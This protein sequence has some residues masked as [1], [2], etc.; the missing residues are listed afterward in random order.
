[1]LFLYKEVLGRELEWLDNVER[2]KGPTRL[3]VVLTEAEVWAL[4][5]QMEGRQYGAGL[6]LMECMRLRVK[7]VDFGYAQ[8]T[9]R[10]GKGEKDRGTILLASLHANLLTH[11]ERVKGRI[12]RSLKTDSA[13]SI[14]RSR[15]PASIRGPAASGVDSAHPVLR[16]PGASAPFLS[17]RNDGSMS[18]RP[19]SVPS[20]HA[21]GQSGA[22]TSTSRPCSGRSRRPSGQPG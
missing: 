19:P 16:P 22:I 7:D 15:S 20:I 8:I 10:E 18:F 6:R 9:V 14:C 12:K 5:V 13:R 3:P 21:R 2:A 17:R 1:M 11:L 4:L